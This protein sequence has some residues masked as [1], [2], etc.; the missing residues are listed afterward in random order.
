M[1]GWT[2]IQKI[3]RVEALLDNLGMQLARARHLPCDI[4]EVAV[5]PRDTESL[6]LYSRDAVLFCGTIESLE[7]WIQGLQWAREYDMLLRL[8]DDKKRDRKEQEERNR[9]LVRR[10]RD[11]EIGIKT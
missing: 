8:S 10:L 9:Q 6:P 11:E 4:D 5:I 7:S 3:K 2:T 1:T